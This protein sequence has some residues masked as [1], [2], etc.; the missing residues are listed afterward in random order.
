MKY[1]SIVGNVKIAM[2]KVMKVKVQRSSALAKKVNAYEFFQCKSLNLSGNDRPST[3]FRI[4]Y[5]LNVRTEL[6]NLTLICLLWL[7]VLPNT[8]LE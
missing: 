4:T 7:E 6:S 5:D 3:L 8:W 1:A 2:Y